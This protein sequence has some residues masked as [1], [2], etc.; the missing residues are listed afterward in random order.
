MSNETYEQIAETHQIDNE[1]A[2]AE[3]E[4]GEQCILLDAA[5]TLA[6]LRRKHNIIFNREIPKEK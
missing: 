4:Y 5:E 1:I 2:E 3:A 6:E